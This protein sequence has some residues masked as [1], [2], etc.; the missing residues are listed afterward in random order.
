MWQ[1]RGS[2]MSLNLSYTF[3]P[4]RRCCS[5]LLLILVVE[6]SLN[7]TVKGY[8]GGSAVLPC[9]SNKDNLTIEEMVVHWRHNESLNVFDI[10]KGKDS[11]DGQK[12]EYKNRAETF[13]HEYVKGNFSLRL[14]NLKSTDAGRY[15]CFITEES[16]FRSV[17]L[18]IKERPLNQGTQTSPVKF[19]TLIPLFSL[20]L[21]CM[22]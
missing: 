11:L 15:S 4:I 18:L 1:R 10:I 17:E 6:G 7:D 16:V 3:T 19:A 12:P 2:R 5:F 14:K 9:S 13:P 20:F 8:F 22:M 21:M